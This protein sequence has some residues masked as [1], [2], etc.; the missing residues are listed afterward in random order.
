MT[1]APDTE[2]Q[3][4][5]SWSDP[6]AIAEAGAGLSGAEFFAAIVAGYRK[7]AWCALG[8]LWASHLLVA[9]WLYHWLPPH[10]GPEPWGQE[11]F[12]TAVV[13]AVVAVAMALAVVVA[14]VGVVVAVEV[15]AGAVVGE[16]VGRDGGEAVLFEGMRE[17]LKCGGLHNRSGVS[18]KGRSSGAG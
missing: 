6:A 7:V 10:K 14:L 1:T 2:R 8:G 17:A 9:H 5:F 3:R 16:R 4:T 13:V 12:I 18:T 11:W 15:A